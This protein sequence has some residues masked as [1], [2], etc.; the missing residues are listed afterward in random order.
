MKTLRV[1]L[2]L[3]ALLFL[4]SACTKQELDDNNIKVDNVEDVG[5]GIHD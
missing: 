4:F 3:A 2:V 1:T 5:G